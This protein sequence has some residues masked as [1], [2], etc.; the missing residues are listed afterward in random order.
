MVVLP[1]QVD[2]RSNGSIGIKSFL[3]TFQFPKVARA[4]ES[5]PVLFQREDFARPRLKFESHPWSKVVVLRRN[6]K[7]DVT[8]SPKDPKGFIEAIDKVVNQLESMRTPPGSE[9]GD[10]SK[11]DLASA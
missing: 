4:Y 5:E 9:D 3:V 7:W 2:V 8:V 10:S 1:K 6:G 11:P